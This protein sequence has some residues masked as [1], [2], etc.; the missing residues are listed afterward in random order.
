MVPGRAGDGERA[1]D[2]SVVEMT[3]KNVSGPSDILDRYY[4]PQWAVAQCFTEVMP[5]VLQTPP[6]SILE[7][8]A[9]GGVF[10]R[11]SRATWPLSRIFAFDVDRTTELWSEADHSWHDDFLHPTS[12]SSSYIDPAWTKYDLVIG[13]PPFTHALAFV[14]RSLQLATTVV[15]ILRQGFLS[16][17]KRAAFFRQHPPIGVWMMPNRP[18]F[19]LDGRTDSADYCWVAWR[20]GHPGSTTL[21][22]LS[23]W[24]R[25]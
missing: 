4:T 18:S 6:K 22:W 10:V 25:R 7:P 16:S 20:R 13:N 19:T 11:A 21:R 5:L 2:G 17:Q 23:S 3:A 14:E 9:G 1:R 15:F 24:E 8:G 12:S